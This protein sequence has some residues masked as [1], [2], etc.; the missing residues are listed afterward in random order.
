MLIGSS[1]FNG[2]KSRGPTGYT[3]ITGA[4]GETGVVGYTGST[5][6]TG[7]T[8]FTGETGSTGFTGQTGATGFTGFTGQTGST[9]FTGFTGQ[10]GSTGFTGFTGQTGSTGF[11]GATGETGATGSTGATGVGLL[12][13]N[14]FED[15][16]ATFDVLSFS[17][18]IGVSLF[19]DYYII[20]NTYD[21]YRAGT[22][23]AV[24]NKNLN[25]I[26]FTDNSTNDLNGSTSD[27]YFSMSI[28]DDD[29]ILTSNITN[30]S[31]SLKISYKIL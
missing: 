14:L 15:K 17:D 13:S 26:T 18:T 24:W 9:G 28:V 6:Q 23:V 8:G 12:Y 2:G 20:N 1:S 3:G 30:D 21:S 29:V 5:G 22:I 7:A 25:I 27:L 11:T 16:D 10:T 19:C 4:T 31:W